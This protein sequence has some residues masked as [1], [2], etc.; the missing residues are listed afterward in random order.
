MTANASLRGPF[1]LSSTNRVLGSPLV[2]N[3]LVKLIVASRGV[4]HD[5][6]DDRVLFITSGGPRE[7]VSEG[8]GRVPERY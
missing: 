4:A 3:L 7:Q 1:T 6:L 8:H 2:T 5:L